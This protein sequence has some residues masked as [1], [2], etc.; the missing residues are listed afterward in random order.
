MKQAVV[1]ASS[2]NVWSV[3]FKQKQGECLRKVTEESGTPNNEEELEVELTEE[4]KA[5]GEMARAI[6]EAENTEEVVEA[7]KPKPKPRRKR[8]PRTQWIVY[9][10]VRL[11][12]SQMYPSQGKHSCNGFC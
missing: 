6:S 3:D 7:P 2:S 9:R 1:E 4:A 11:Q 12:L 8:K 10:I 5:I